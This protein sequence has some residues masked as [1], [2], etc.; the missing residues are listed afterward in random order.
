[1]AM[2]YHIILEK[3]HKYS[4]CL[5]ACVCVLFMHVCIAI[6]QLSL[7]YTNNSKNSSFT[8][9]NQPSLVAN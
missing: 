2:D 5:Y 4:Q 6:F 3:A 7:I 9:W 8:S 1:M